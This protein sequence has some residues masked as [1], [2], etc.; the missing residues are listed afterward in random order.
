MKK[1]YINSEISDKPFGGGLKFAR[2][3]YYYLKSN[4]F[5]LAKSLEENDIDYII[6]VSYFKKQYFLFLVSHW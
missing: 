3:L 1:F 4:G 5:K 6:N 2:N